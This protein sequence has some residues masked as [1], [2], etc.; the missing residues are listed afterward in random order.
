MLAPM[1]K[2]L[3]GLGNPGASYEA[4]RHNA[5]FWWI[6]A[7]AQT[8]RVSLKL[9]RDVQGRVGRYGT[10]GAEAV[11]LLTPQTYMNLSGQSVSALARFYKIAPEHILVAHDEL[12]LPPGQVR[13]KLGG[14]SGGHNGL[15]DIQAQLG[16][17]RFWRLRL[18]IGHPGVKDEVPDYVLRKPTAADRLAI[19]QAIEKS[20]LA[21]DVMLQGHMERAMMTLH[22]KPQ[23]PKPPRR[24]PA[25][26]AS[27]SDDSQ[28]AG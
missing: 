28:T 2:L 11:H 25:K 15:K 17:D 5:G 23:R 7:V 26:E 21:L 22:A 8:L 20:L 27:G 16:T 18:G 1:M 4:T 13:L 3:V 6:D 14:S 19:D 24:E 12:D 10:T 9:Q